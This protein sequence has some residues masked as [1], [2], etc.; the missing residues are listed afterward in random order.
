VRSNEQWDYVMND[1]GSL[2]GKVIL[3]DTIVL[4]IRTKKEVGAF[5]GSDFK[6]YADRVIYIKQGE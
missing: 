4:C 3:S 2:T 6:E 5:W 1:D